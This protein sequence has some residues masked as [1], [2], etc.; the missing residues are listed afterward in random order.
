VKAAIDAIVTRTQLSSAARITRYS[1]ATAL[2][3]GC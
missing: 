3:Y 1:I 2:F